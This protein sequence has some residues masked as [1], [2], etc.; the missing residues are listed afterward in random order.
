MTHENSLS[1]SLFLFDIDGTLLDVRGDG[2]RAL[3]AAVSEVL[4]VTT[5]AELPLKGAIDRLIFRG[6]YESTEL[7]ASE[8]DIHWEAFKEKYLSGLYTLN[9]KS[10]VLFPNALETV[11]YLHTCSNIA[12]ATGNIRPGAVMKLAHFGLDGFFPCGGFGDCAE[13]RAHLVDNAICNA[14]EYYKRRFDRSRVFMLGD[15]EKDVRAAH[16]N[17]IVPV[18]IDHYGVHGEVLDEWKVNYYGTFAGINGFLSHVGARR[19]HEGVLRF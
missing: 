6:F 2:K 4:S 1:D 3:L 19:A 12:V 18:L 10:W 15:T 5:N 9:G 17:G 7:P 16:D 13:S 8:I 11:K 14:E